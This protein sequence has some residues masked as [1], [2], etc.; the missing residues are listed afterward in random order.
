MKQAGL[1]LL[2]KLVQTG[3]IHPVI[4]RRYPLSD[5]RDA[6]AYIETG[7]PRAKVIIT[8]D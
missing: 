6:L 8:P 2:G 5:T 1:D 7:H 4:D 3:K